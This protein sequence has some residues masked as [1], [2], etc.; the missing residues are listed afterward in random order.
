M[1]PLDPILHEL[2]DEHRSLSAPA[3]VERALAAEFRKR[4]KRG[5]LPW[6]CAAAAMSASA[7]AVLIF[8]Q[9]PTE[10][11]ELNVSAPPAP[12]VR[13]TPSP[14]AAAAPRLTV[15]RTKRPAAPA[16]PEITTDFFPLRV[17]PVLAPGELAQVVRTRVP[18]RELARFG[19]T[20]IGYSATRA[21]APDIR[22]DVVFGNDGTARAIRFVHDSQ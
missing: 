5:W 8:V 18:R 7:A 20:S 11:I 16:A 3:S 19:L 1:T 10:T 4:H 2:A 6:L 14:T 9:P 22:A 17:G 21:A 13:F 15:A 12:E